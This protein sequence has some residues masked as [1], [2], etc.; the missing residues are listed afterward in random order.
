MGLTVLMSHNLLELSFELDRSNDPFEDIS[1]DVTS[2]KCDA[3]VLIHKPTNE[4]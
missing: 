4:K 1:T 2:P 3:M